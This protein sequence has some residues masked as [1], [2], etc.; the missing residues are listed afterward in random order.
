M[1][2]W[3][4]RFNDVLD[5]P[6][7]GYAGEMDWVNEEFKG[8]R[9]LSYLYTLLIGEYVPGDK[10]YHYKGVIKQPYVIHFIASWKP[11]LKQNMQTKLDDQGLYYYKL[12]DKHRLN[13]ELLLSS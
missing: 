12:W 10:I 7:T 9:M 1:N 3:H 11:P 6:K 4:G 5:V 13:V 2:T 8:G